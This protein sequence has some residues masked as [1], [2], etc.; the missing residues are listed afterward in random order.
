MDM[1][2]KASAPIPQHVT[3][4]EPD[5]RRQAA[6]PAVLWRYR[7]LAWMLLSKDFKIRYRNAVLGVAW[8]LL[9]PLGMMAVMTVVFGV[10]A[11]FP[12][13]GLPY[14]LFVLSGLAIWG[15]IAGSLGQGSSCL[16]R[17]TGLLSKVY[18][19]RLILPLNAVI[20]GMIDFC[21]VL[22]LLLAA[23][24]FYQV[25]IGWKLLTL[26]GF[27]F[28]AAAFCFG[29]S[30]LLAPL[31]LRFHDVS[32]FI[33]FIIRPWMFAT[34][35]I[36]P[37]SIIPEGWQWIPDLNPA[38]P[39]VEG[40]RWA[41]FPQSPAPTALGLVLLSIWILVLGRF[42]IAYFAAKEATFAD[43]L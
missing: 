24:L 30:T 17:H 25:P 20:S 36:Y 13:D 35:I 31:A 2:S 16:R 41:L 5:S 19:P 12:S 1:L 37:R 27:L 28:L 10:L 23:L 3:V 32:Y 43:E 7:N 39:I 29:A 22:A 6:S 18:F 15:Y 4:V 40:V 11:R 8:V 26:P 33:G 38:T 9:Q 42:G 34:P 14:P 21:A